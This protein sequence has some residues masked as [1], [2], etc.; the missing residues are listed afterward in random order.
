M[1]E[2]Q[3]QEGSSNP[4]KSAAGYRD[5][6]MAELEKKMNTDIAAMPEAV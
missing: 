6:D 2:G 1:T 5:P 4:T 3:H